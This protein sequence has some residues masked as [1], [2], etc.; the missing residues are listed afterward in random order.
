MYVQKRPC[1][2]CQMTELK[3]RRIGEMW[4]HG[5][6]MSKISKRLNVKVSALR[7]HIAVCGQRDFYAEGGTAAAIRL[8]VED[9][10]ANL[11]ACATSGQRP[12]KVLLRS[13]DTAARS[14]Q[15]LHELQSQSTVKHFADAFTELASL[16]M[17]DCPVTAPT[18]IE[19]LV[20]EYP[21]VRNALLEKQETHHD[22]DRADPGAS[23]PD[24]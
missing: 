12:T 3:R 11:I 2:V 23:I 16:Y 21:I 22:Q 8:A 17:L 7:A 4:A 19:G 13:L 15:K 9:L 24:W 6:S 1:P 18:A 10:N 20:N 5:A 14:L